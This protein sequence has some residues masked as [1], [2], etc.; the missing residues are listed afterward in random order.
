MADRAY[1][2]RPADCQSCFTTWCWDGTDNST[3]PSSE[4][5]PVVG[6]IP[7]FISTNNLGSRGQAAGSSNV[8]AG[9]SSSV[10]ASSAS[11]SQ[12]QA[13]GVRSVGVGKGLMGLMGALM[14]AVGAGPALVLI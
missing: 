10:L 4:Y 5:E 7:T 1:T 8:V 6:T 9:S 3:T 2:T 13:A 14:V 11:A 12:S